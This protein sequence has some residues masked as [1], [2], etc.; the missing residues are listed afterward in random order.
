MELIPGG[1]LE[2]HRLQPTVIGGMAGTRATRV[3]LTLKDDTTTEAT[4]DRGHV[5]PG[6]TVFWGVF[7]AQPI[8]ATAYDTRGHVVEDHRLTP[9]DDPVDCMTR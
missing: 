4:V 2:N 5:A 7:D 3:V 6:A 8:R 1:T 9:C